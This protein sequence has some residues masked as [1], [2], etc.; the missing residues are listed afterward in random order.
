MSSSYF[1]YLRDVLK[2]SNVRGSIGFP[3]N[4]REPNSTRHRD[5]CSARGDGH[6]LDDAWAYA[7]PGGGRGASPGG[8]PGEGHVALL[9]HSLKTTLL[10]LINLP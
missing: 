10:A 4:D 1:G 2:K 8:E 6:V 9:R 3:P 5:E 7:A